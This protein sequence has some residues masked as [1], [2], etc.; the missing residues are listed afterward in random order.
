MRLAI[1]THN[2]IRGDGQGRVNYE[3]ARAAMAQGAHVTLISNRVEQSLLDEGA[4]LLY[5]PISTGKVILVKGQEFAFRADRIVKNLPAGDVVMGCGFTL[6]C[7]HNVNVVHFVH[8]S[9]LRSPMH[10][11]RQRRSLY[12]A[13]QWLYTAANARMEKETLRQAK[14]VVA[15]S[16]QVRNDLI[17]SGIP[18]DKIQVIHNGVDLKEFIPGIQGR[19]SLGLPVDVPLAFF[20]GGLRTHLKNVDTILKALVRSPDLHL[21]IAGDTKGSPFPDMARS[22]GVADRTHFLGYR[23]D[24]PALMKA[25]DMFVFPSR[26]ES[27]SLVLLEAMA[28]GLPVITAKTVGASDLVIEEAGIVLDDPNDTDGLVAAMNILVSN[29]QVRKSM[30]EAAR[31]VAEL[32]SWEEMGTQYLTLLK[33]AENL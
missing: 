1:V 16:D 13:Y 33:E 28:S 26:Y 22:L 31:K 29:P 11:C 12:S 5:V 30:G 2:V 9:W 19:E 27:F 32:N 21:A 6:S 3:I 8:S 4:E 10:I 7:A 14:R 20:A 25:S 15:V 23:R 24:I 17:T 18:S